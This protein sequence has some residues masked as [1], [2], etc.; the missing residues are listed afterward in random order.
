MFE[1]V[2]FYPGGLEKTRTCD[3]GDLLP[4]IATMLQEYERSH[5][6]YE[7]QRNYAVQWRRVRE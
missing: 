3:V 6:T 2:F 1:V 5:G 7:Y 4:T